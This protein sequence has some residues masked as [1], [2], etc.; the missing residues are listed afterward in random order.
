MSPGHSTSKL[1]RPGDATRAK[2]RTETPRRR[3]DDTRF[4]DLTRAIPE[5]R[6]I[7]RGRS[8]RLLTVGGFSLVMVAL[9][10]ALFVLPVKSWLRQGDALSTKQRQLKTLQ[11]AN[12][13]LANEVSRLGTR[14]GIEEA[15]RQEIG[16]VQ[17]GEIRLTLLPTP[18]APTKLPG[19]WP[20]DTFSRIVA[21]RTAAV[22]RV[23]ASPGTTDAAKDTVTTLAGA[24]N[25][26]GG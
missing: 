16:Y 18:D 10:A 3:R 11:E 22:T 13:Q 24:S 2:A 15:A 1:R 12:S 20:F 19:G 23:E 17:R 6:R 8:P 26:V 5:E 7:V 4:G 9:V 25:T 21:V 14:Q